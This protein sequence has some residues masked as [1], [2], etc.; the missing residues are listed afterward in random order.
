[1][2]VTLDGAAGDLARSGRR[3]GSV[4][5]GRRTAQDP[6]PTSGAGVTE[7]GFYNVLGRQFYAGLKAKF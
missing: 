6:Q 3:H 5:T 4:I 1:V 2:D 7:V